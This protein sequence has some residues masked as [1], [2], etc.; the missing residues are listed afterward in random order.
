MGAVSP[1]PF[2]DEAFME[3][4]KTR[5]I[6]PTVKGLGKEGI[7]Y[8]GFIFFGLINVNGEPYVIEYNARLGDPETEV[9]I[10]RIKSDLFDLLLGVATNDLASRKI[11]ID[12][13]TVTTVMMVSGGY[14]GDYEKGKTITGLEDVKES[15]VFHAGTKISDDS[16]VTAGGR[17]LA[18]SS[19]GNTIEEALRTSYRNAELINYEG[20][21]YRNDIGFDLK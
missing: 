17:V 18:I 1:V 2:A 15:V 10:P 4:V 11:E 20:R 19:W 5:I 8:K 21:Y 6:D 13:R 7:I 3:K 14:P 12:E 16:V 9:I